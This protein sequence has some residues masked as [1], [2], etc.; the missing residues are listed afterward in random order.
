MDVDSVDNFDNVDNEDKHRKR[1]DHDFDGDVDAEDEVRIVE[2]EHDGGS[3]IAPIAPTTKTAAKTPAKAA[4]AA[5]AA[6]AATT[7][8]PKRSA[9]TSSSATPEE[10]L[11]REDRKINKINKG[12]AKKYERKASSVLM[13]MIEAAERTRG[14]KSIA[15]KCMLN[16]FKGDPLYDK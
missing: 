2:N 6:A 15:L 10:L 7:T 4:A 8:T 14:P 11:S 12:S 5:A 13:D 3:P 9:A 16:D 1:K